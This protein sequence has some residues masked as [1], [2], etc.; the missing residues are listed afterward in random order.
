[1]TQDYMRK[2]PI[3]GTIAEMSYEKGCNDVLDEIEECFNPKDDIVKQWSAIANKIEE[4][5]GKR[6]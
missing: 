2:N 3:Y 5:R 1:M 4:L 6:V